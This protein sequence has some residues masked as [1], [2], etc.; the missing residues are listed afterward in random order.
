MS[1]NILLTG[2]PRSGTTLSCLLLSKINDML[3]LNEPMRTARHKSRPAA[4]EAIPA[5]FKQTR[6]DILERGVATARVVNGKMTDN[7]FSNEKGQRKTL[8]SKEEFRVNKPLSPNFALAIKH[9]ALFT[10]LLED[11]VKTYPVYAF[12]RN[13]V[14]VFGSWNSLNIP[15]SR[16]VVR[17]AEWLDPA[18]HQE[19]EAIK[20]LPGKQLHIL[21]WYCQQYVKYLP[22]SNVI[23]Y[24]DVVSTNGQVLAAIHPGAT[25][26]TEQLESKNRNK[27]YDSA[28]IQLLGKKLLQQE[29]HACWHFYTPEDVEKMLS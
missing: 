23:R 19:L 22:A 27:V 4:I 1:T 6:K 7:H 15:A 29:Q 26:L 20:D 12:V 24:E 14:A 3:A 9:N 17:A 25:E 10:I 21:D 28:T 16:G 8:V 5:F 11:L 2:L 13:P 18:F